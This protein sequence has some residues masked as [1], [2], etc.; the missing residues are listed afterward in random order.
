M[1]IEENLP[2]NFKGIWIPKSI[3]INEALSFFEKCL[4]AEIDSLD[5]EEKGCTAS[6]Q[7]LCKFFGCKERTLQ[8]ALSRLKS[9]GLIIYEKYDGRIRTLKSCVKTT[10]EIFSTSDPQPGAG[11]ENR[12]SHLR[13]TAPLSHDASIIENKE[14]VL[15]MRAHAREA[16][17]K[18]HDLSK[19]RREE[20]KKCPEM[21]DWGKLSE[22]VGYLKAILFPDGTKISDKNIEMWSKNYSIWKLKKCIHRVLRMI[23]KGKEL[24]NPQGLMY[25]LLSDP[26][27]D[28]TKVSEDAREQAEMW[29]D[30]NQMWFR[31]DDDYISYDGTGKDVPLALGADKVIE[32]MKGW[33][34]VR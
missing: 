10:Y 8:D 7:Y 16:H 22:R 3:W 25:K 2:R 29:M 5:D 6:N 1:S 27:F 18:T 21:K 9:L 24:T 15:D 32:V 4:W 34:N 30:L 14:E 23:L 17:D 33:A 12:T 28:S 13:K 31:I 20:E 26:N 11:A 19:M